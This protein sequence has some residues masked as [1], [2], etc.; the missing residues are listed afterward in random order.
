M[1]YFPLRAWTDK[2][3]W[4]HNITV[5]QLNYS[6]WVSWE[7]EKKGTCIKVV[8]SDKYKTGKHF[9]IHDLPFND[10]YGYWKR[11]GM[12]FHYKEPN[13]EPYDFCVNAQGEVKPYEF[14]KPGSL[15]ALQSLAPNR[16]ALIIKWAQEFVDQ[17]TK[18]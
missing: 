4:P 2:R 5:N 18:G 6:R 12:E 7:R 1:G 8:Y 13:N 3:S 17:L 16:R 10:S 15:S 14:V 9:T 11:N